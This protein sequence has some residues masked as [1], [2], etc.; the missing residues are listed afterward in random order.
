MVDYKKSH[1]NLSPNL[2]HLNFQKTYPKHRDLDCCQVDRVAEVEL[3]EEVA[4]WQAE[5]AVMVQLVEQ[6][7]IEL[8]CAEQ[9]LEDEE[10]HLH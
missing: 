2:N 8:V 3:A 6:A 1:Q 5:Q 9:E 10:V 7:H 4:I